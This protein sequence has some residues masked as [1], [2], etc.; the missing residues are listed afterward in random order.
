MNSRI[1]LLSAIFSL[2]IILVTKAIGQSH[3]EHTSGMT[4]HQ[5]DTNLP[6]ATGQ[7]AFEALAEIV[8]I[9]ED[10][11]NTDWT[12]VNID[13]LR[14]HLV[15]MNELTLNA[16]VI[17]QQLDEQTIQ[18]QVEGTARTLSAIKSMVPT[19]A[20]MVRNLKDWNIVVDSQPEGIML[21]VS[22]NSTEEFLKLKALGFFGF[23]TI[24][25]HHQL[26]HLQMA[27]GAGH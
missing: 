26:H 13:N 16:S 6:S 14:E 18:F 7:S 2:F 10:D 1:I 3:S 9:L 4:H 20:H 27:T 8:A 24:G 17:T 11:S 22:T 21:K 12:T 25:A 19:H 5:G 15:D 23:M